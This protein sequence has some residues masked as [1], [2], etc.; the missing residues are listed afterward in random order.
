MSPML[1]QAMAE[2]RKLPD[3]EQDSIAA[4]ILDE[5]ADDRRWEESLARSP[6]KLAALAARERTCTNRPMPSGE[7]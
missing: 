5:I 3:E 7:V 2:A 4:L 6:D 1:D